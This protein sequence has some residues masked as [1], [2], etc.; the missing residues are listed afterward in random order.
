VVQ[1]G[2]QRGGFR[3]VSAV[4]QRTGVTVIFTCLLIIWLRLVDYSF[5]PSRLGNDI[6]WDKDRPKLA[7]G[8][9]VQFAFLVA[10]SMIETFPAEEDFRFAKRAW[11]LTT[12]QVLML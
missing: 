7:F 9:N 1:P 4:V 2:Q 11:P 6:A 5:V 10:G 8:A 3:R 12:P